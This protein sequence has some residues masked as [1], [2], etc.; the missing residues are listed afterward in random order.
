MEVKLVVESWGSVKSVIAAHF[1][2]GF[3]CE[4]HT[5][6]AGLKRT[7]CPEASRP[8]HLNLKGKLGTEYATYYSMLASAHPFHLFTVL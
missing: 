2:Y 4:V 5:T 3:L 8:P 1:N 7:T 6:E